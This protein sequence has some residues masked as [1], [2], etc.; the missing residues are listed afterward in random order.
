MRLDGHVN[1][2]DDGGDDAMDDVIGGGDGD[3]DDA[4][5]GRVVTFDR[6]GLEEEMMDCHVK[7]EIVSEG[8]VDRSSDYECQGENN[9]D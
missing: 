1:M 2:C 9:D 6:V 4:V 5:E 3:G 8:V 7:S